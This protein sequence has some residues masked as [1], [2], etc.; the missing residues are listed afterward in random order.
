ML[1]NIQEVPVLTYVLAVH[2]PAS[3]QLAVFSQVK[4]LTLETPSPRVAETSRHVSV[5]E[6]LL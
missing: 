3:L 1:W 5:N 4:A 2:P 6:L